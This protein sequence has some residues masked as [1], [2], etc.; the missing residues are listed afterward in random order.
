M[1]IIVKLKLKKLCY[2]VFNYFN[3]KK[4]N[5]VLEVRRRISRLSLRLGLALL[6]LSLRTAC[7]LPCVLATLR[8]CRL[9]TLRVRRLLSKGLCT[10]RT[11]GGL[12]RRDERRLSHWCDSLW[13]LCGRHVLLLI[14]LGLEIGEEGRELKYLA[15]RA[16]LHY[17]SLLL[18]SICLILWLVE[19]LSK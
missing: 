19:G 18:W 11:N 1:S 5:D 16:S 2:C 10:A 13:H 7:W 9:L 6:R 15:N 17:A 4:R 8:V 3:F 12:L 14:E